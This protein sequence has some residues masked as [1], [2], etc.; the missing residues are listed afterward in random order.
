MQA[1]GVGEMRKTP[2]TYRTR[3]GKNTTPFGQC[4]SVGHGAAWCRARGL[5][6]RR[7]KVL[8]SVAL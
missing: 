8:L 4:G 1:G 3:R 6:V 7:E 2:S 5:V